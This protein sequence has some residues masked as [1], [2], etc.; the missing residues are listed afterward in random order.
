MML[1]A[2]SVA[3]GGAASV[4]S[5]P[6][7]KRL[8]WE[9]NQERFLSSLWIAVTHSVRSIRSGVNTCLNR[10]IS[11]RESDRQAR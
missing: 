11:R 9:G 4:A 8:G 3:A 10:Q 2:A 5:E 6:I 7:V 1:L